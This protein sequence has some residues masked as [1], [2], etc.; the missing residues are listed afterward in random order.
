MNKTIEFYK[1]K[2]VQSFLMCIEIYNK[3]TIDYRLEGPVFFLCNAWELMLK[4]KLLLDGK[5][6]Y[7]PNKKGIRRFIS[8]SEAAARVMTNEK[9]PVRENLKVII[10]LRNLATHS[11]IPEF[12]II[13][14]PFMAFNV[15]AYANKM[16]DYLGV[17]ISEYIKNDLLSLFVNNRSVNKQEI[18]SK[19]G[20]GITAMF[21]EKEGELLNAISN[22]G[23]NS[24]ASKVE[25]NI[26]R[27]NDKSKADYLFY[28]TNNPKDK[29]VVYV[30]REVDYN[31]NYPYTHHQ[32]AKEINSIIV[33]NNMAFTPIREPQIKSDGSVSP[34]FTYKCFDMLLKEYNIKNN[35]EYC[36]S[37]E[38]GKG[39]VYKYSNKL[40]TYFISLIADNKDIVANLNKKV[41]PRSK[42][43]ST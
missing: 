3:P 28:T 8:L 35:K 2:S 16:Y 30:D 26:S 12:D 36:I 7:Y 11:I 43:I 6:I 15:Q 40:T 23:N 19:Y 31:K 17:N 22:N 21:E 14:S 4:A 24:I 37:F 39:I 25:I 1:N 18:L 34:L 33:K 38:N 27:I 32:I 41:N 42:G 29:N 20:E 10:S 5:D 13:Y 9:D